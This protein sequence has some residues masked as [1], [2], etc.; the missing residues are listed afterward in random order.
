MI[1]KKIHYCWFGRNPFPPIIEKCIATWQTVLPEYEIKRW[2]ESNFDVSQNNYV[3]EAYEA[4]KYAFV[5]D[6]ARFDILYREGGIYLDTDVEILRNLDNFLHHKMFTGFENE[7]CVAPGLILGAIPKANLIGYLRNY[8]LDKSFAKSDGSFN[9]ESIVSI[10]T[11]ILLDRGLRLDGEFQI[12]EEIA[13]YPTD[14]FSPLQFHTG[15]LCKTS[16]TVSIHHYA[17]SW[18][19]YDDKFKLFFYRMFTNLLGH[20]LFNQIKN[21]KKYI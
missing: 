16:N 20:N 14:Y 4:K 21:Y 9:M 8:Y 7:K 10:M 11:K 13:I 2:D 12:V 15:K 19:S 6:F 17:G 18:L 3:K 5:S 1:P